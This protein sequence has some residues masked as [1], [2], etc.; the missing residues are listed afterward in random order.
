MILKFWRKSKSEELIYVNAS[1][2]GLFNICREMCGLALR[3]DLFD[4]RI[5]CDIHETIMGFM[6][7]GACLLLRRLATASTAAAVKLAPAKSL[8][9]RSLFK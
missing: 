6:P 8:G 9:E 2:A 7:D 1:M 3:H 5:F 4:R